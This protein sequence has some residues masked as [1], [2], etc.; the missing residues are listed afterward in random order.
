MSQDLITAAP[1]LGFPQRVRYMICETRY[2]IHDINGIA[3]I[4]Y[5][6]TDVLKTVLS[7]VRVISIITLCIIIAPKALAAQGQRDSDGCTINT[8]HWYPVQ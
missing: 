1:I 2:A 4:L 8:A 6:E 7:S 5:I 3:N